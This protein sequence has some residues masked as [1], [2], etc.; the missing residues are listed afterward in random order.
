MGK[1]G[2][3]NLDPQTMWAPNNRLFANPQ[4]QPLPRSKN[5]VVV[6]DKL[7]RMQI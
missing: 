7:Q 1:I 6:A 3:R 2:W 4:L 5:I